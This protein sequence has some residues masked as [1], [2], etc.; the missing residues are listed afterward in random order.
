[1]ITKNI[2]ACVRPTVA[3]QC[4]IS[5][6]EA[7]IAT[8]LLSILFLGLAF[9]L[10]RGLVSQRYMATQNLALLEIREGLQQKGIKNLCDGGSPDS[11]QIVGAVSIA[12]NCED[13]PE[14]DV[15]ILGFERSVTPRSITLTTES[16]SVSEGLFGGDGVIKISNQ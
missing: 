14:I 5:L 7:M 3:R 6:I 13:K 11:L 4:G 9:V 2:T 8:L 10:S 16:N 12:K 1:M 15:N